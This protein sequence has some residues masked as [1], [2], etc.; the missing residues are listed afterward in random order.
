MD[1]A[2]TE[3]VVEA[4]RLKHHVEAESIDLNRGKGSAL[5]A[6]NIWS[7]E[8][9]RAT[10]Y[11]ITTA[12]RPLPGEPGGDGWEWGHAFEFKAPTEVSAND[13]ADAI[14]ESLPNILAGD[15]KARERN[16]G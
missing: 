11:P 15:R 1:I 4:L 6:V 5:W 3:T 2:T 16:G 14:V 10:R 9:H 13:L 12:V 7:F 8:D